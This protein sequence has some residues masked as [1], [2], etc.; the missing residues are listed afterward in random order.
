MAKFLYALGLSSDYGLKVQPRLDVFHLYDFLFNRVEAGGCAKVSAHLVGDSERHDEVEERY[1]TVKVMRY[2][3]SDKY[4][5]VARPE[6][7]RY[8]LDLFHEAYVGAAE[9]RD[10]DQQPFTD[11]YEEVL[12]RELE[13]SGYWASPIKSPDGSCHAQ[14]HF[15]FDDGIRTS[16]VLLDKKKKTELKRTLFTVL[17]GELPTLKMMHSKLEWTG[18]NEVRLTHSNGRD[19]WVYDTVAH[20]A[21]LHYGRAEDG[22]PGGQYDLGMMYRRGQGVLVDEALAVHW[23]EKAAAQGHERAA[24]AL[25]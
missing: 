9:A 4:A 20:T 8:L 17:S 21:R 1:G 12:K 25:T 18:A 23:L 10:W 14:V 19:Y 5:A 6:G 2:F 13:F 22:D 16:F 11:A 15:H 3:D 7:D 24:K